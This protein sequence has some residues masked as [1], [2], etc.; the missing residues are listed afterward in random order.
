MSDI[1]QFEPGQELRE[2]EVFVVTRCICGWAGSSFPA[3][4]QGYSEAMLQFEEHRFE[5]RHQVI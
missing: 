5:S 2:G 3:S 1:H 4:E